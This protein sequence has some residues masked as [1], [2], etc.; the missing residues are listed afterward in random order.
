MPNS[1]NSRKLLFDLAE[2]RRSRAR[3]ADSVLDHSARAIEIE[4]IESRVSELERAGKR[5]N[6]IG[7][8]E[9]AQP[10]G[11]FKAP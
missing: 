7:R 2:P 10:G 6:I 9:H 5:Q 8:Y 3:A 1:S 11:A 4:D